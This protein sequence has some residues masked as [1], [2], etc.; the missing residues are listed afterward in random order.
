MNKFDKY[1]LILI[2]F[3]IGLAMSGMIVSVMWSNKCSHY[4]QAIKEHN[5]KL[6]TLKEE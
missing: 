5:I 2:S 1:E 3:L 4:E 6:Q